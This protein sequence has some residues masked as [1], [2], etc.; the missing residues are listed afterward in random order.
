MTARGLG[1]S[2]ASLA[3]IVSIA[4][5]LS[6]STAP[7]P[8]V[9]NP[10]S[11]PVS[12]SVD[13]ESM[14]ESVLPG[15][16]EFLFPNRVVGEKIEEDWRRGESAN[17]IF[18]R[19]RS[20]VII[21][22]NDNAKKLDGTEEE[23]VPVIGDDRKSVKFKACSLVLLPKAPETSRE[24]E[25]ASSEKSKEEAELALRERVRQ[26]LV[27]EAGKIVLY[28][29]SPI[30]DLNALRSGQINFASFEK[31][32]MSETVVVRSA[33]RSPTSEDDLYLTAQGVSFTAKQIRAGEDVRFNFGK[34]GGAGKWL[35]IDLDEPLRFDD[36]SFV[37]NAANAADVEKALATGGAGLESDG[38]WRRVFE[39]VVDDGNLGGGFAIER[40]ELDWL[41]DHFRFY[42][43]EIPRPGETAKKDGAGANGG[44][45]KK[46]PSQRIEIRCANGVDFAPDVQAVGGWCVRFNRDVAV[47]AYQKNEIA[48]QISCDALF[49]YLQDPELAEL[50]R[51]K[52]QI[53]ADALSSAPVG[54]LTRLSPTILRAQGSDAEPASVKVAATGAELKADS[55][56]YRVFERKVE[57]TALTPENAAPTSGNSKNVGGGVVVSDGGDTRFE[58]KAVVLQMDEKFDLKSLVAG[59]NG[60]FETVLREGD[61]NGNGGNRFGIVDGVGDANA[62]SGGRRFSAIW[63]GALRVAPEER[64]AP[65]NA[66]AS[67]PKTLKT[68]KTLK[69]STAGGVAFEIEG[70]GSF[71]ANEA[72]FW[73]KIEEP[74][75][76]GD[77]ADD[78]DL[79]KLFSQ[80]TP[81]GASFRGDVLFKA[82]RGFA[83]ISDSVDVL[84]GTPTE[85]ATEVDEPNAARA[86]AAEDG[87]GA[88]GFLSDASAFSESV[89]TEF[90]IEGRKLE[91]WCLLLDD[92]ATGR[93]TAGVDVYNLRLEGGVSLVERS[94]IGGAET[95]RLVA[96]KA[97]IRSPGTK[98]ARVR[99]V[100]APA[101]SFETKELRLIGG[102]VVV[103]CAGNNF[104]VFGPGKLTVDPPKDAARKLA[105]QDDFA[106]FFSDESAEIVWSKSMT[107]DGTTLEFQSNPGED[108]S[109][110]QRKQTL[111]CPLVRASLARPISIFEL[112]VLD[113][114]G[115]S[116]RI[117]VER[118]E[119][120]G[121]ADRPVKANALAF[122]EGGDANGAEFYRGV[123]RRIVFKRS[124]GEFEASEGGSLSATIRDTGE[125]S[126]KLGGLAAFAAAD[127][128]GNDAGK[129]A[130][131]GDGENA[132]PRWTKLH[133]TFSG[134]AI[135]SLE[136][137]A[138]L[139]QGGVRAVVCQTSDRNASPNVDDVDSLPPGSA[140]L[141]AEQARVTFGEAQK[142]SG[143]AESTIEVEARQNVVFRRDD[144]I[145]L[146]EALRY[147]SEK[148]VVVL[149]GS[150]LNKGT[151]YR[152]KYRGAPREGNVYF[153]R[154]FFYLDSQRLEVENLEAGFE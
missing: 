141:T 77:K 36:V 74:E 78:G 1:Y 49:L 29:S 56:L 80:M 15:A 144:A 90:E 14:L 22:K 127:G 111:V 30:A 40:I 54:R 41:R 105:E 12:E 48:A 63:K 52:P 132:A 101:A 95:T 135:G 122:G 51:K 42:W 17:F 100:G 33:M 149:L 89:E 60:K 62:P 131:N 112:D 23:D 68:L 154:A 125:N 79:A 142:A 138:I 139:T 6:K 88:G 109:I 76:D 43:D 145:G 115:A 27:F 61:R 21:F 108:V 98:R 57:A 4:F 81:L 106:R 71:R 133:M 34:N 123:F 110:S 129:I 117:E 102:D 13:R 16:S 46:D 72:D 50:A 20:Y 121:S 140:F 18:P 65:A 99:L 85:V 143:A 66:N 5:A 8:P 47:V 83:K 67:A 152:Q 113:D 35:T 28:F 150:D 39:G 45:S 38:D 114:D 97:T 7:L 93:K 104:S 9:L 75:K 86:I 26:A 153:S 69:T 146:C 126:G 53:A 128:S 58:A 137:R 134:K 64:P 96:E 44:E 87:G 148:N 10:I 92:A 84:F 55:I 120:V 24:D 70:V 91:L 37:S 116:D 2:L 19:D 130:A 32:E 119:C 59:E 73:G 94:K 136:K 25:T 107:F 31:G 124:T 147:V 11:N 3:A 151:F 82:P 103:D 118:I